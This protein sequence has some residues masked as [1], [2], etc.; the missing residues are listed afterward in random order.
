MTDTEIPT[1]WNYVIAYNRREYL[2]WCYE[3]GYDYQRRDWIPAHAA[4]WLRAHA[5]PDC[6]YMMTQRARERRDWPAIEA[7]L[8]SLSAVRVYAPHEDPDMGLTA[9]AAALDALDVHVRV[10]RFHVSCFPVDHEDH[11]SFNVMVEYRGRDLWAVVNGFGQCLNTDGEWDWEM[12]PSEREDDWLASHR[13]TVRD[14]VR[15]ARDVAPKL[16]VNGWTVDDVKSGRD[17]PSGRTVDG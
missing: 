7:E 17:H 16:I 1:S 6:R 5:E 15:M 3:H 9:S 4:S 14:A 2:Q 11:G 8:E 12:R 10:T 13:F